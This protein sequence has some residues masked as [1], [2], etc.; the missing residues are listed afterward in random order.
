MNNQDYMIETAKR[1]LGI[2]LSPPKAPIPTMSDGDVCAYIVMTRA[3][4]EIGSWLARL[5]YGTVEDSWHAADEVRAEIN[6]V[7]V[8]SA[9]LRE[10][11]G[12][13]L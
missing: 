13:K 4:E 6:D 11:T 1:A 3:P 8:M 9:K 5:V 7:R 12:G 10:L 2:D